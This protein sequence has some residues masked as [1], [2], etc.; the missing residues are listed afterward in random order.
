MEDKFSFSRLLNVYFQRVGGGLSTS[1]DSYETMESFARACNLLYIRIATATLGVLLLLFIPFDMWFMRSWPHKLAMLNLWKYIFASVMFLTYVVTIRVKD[2]DRFRVWY[3]FVGPASVCTFLSGGIG[4]AMGPLSEPWLYGFLFVPFAN[5]LT[6]MEL[7]HRIVTTILFVFVGF[8][9][10]A[11][12][13][14]QHYSYPFLPSFFGWVFSSTL[15][16]IGAGHIFT[17]LVRGNFRRSLELREHNANLNALVEQR[18]QEVTQAILK[19]EVAQDNT[20]QEIARDLHDELG[21]LIVLHSLSIQRYQTENSEHLATAAACDEFL[22]QVESIEQGARRVVREL[23][24]GLNL[25]GPIA[26]T[27]EKLLDS[28]SESAQVELEW[29]IEPEELALDEKVGFVL[30]RI[31][32]EA[33]NNIRKYAE[34]SKVEVSV[35]Y[36]SGVLTASVRDNGVGFDTSA[37]R[38]GFGLHGMEERVRSINGTLSISSKP[39]K[40]TELTLTIPI[41]TSTDSKP[42]IQQTLAYGSSIKLPS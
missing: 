19:L 16:S 27:L 42:L 34:A 36:E 21:H 25:K 9:G 20:R 2:V 5:V 41:Q 1:P 33:F 24:G 3:A 22:K 38:T 28:L 35:F 7:G 31:I 8:L 10:L 13:Y 40:G 11:L 18:T 15:L 6:V 30:T 23:R 39:G 26:F 14:P 12:F 29:I 32:Q 4:G 37:T 17:S